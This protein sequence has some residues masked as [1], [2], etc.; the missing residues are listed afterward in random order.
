MGKAE[1]S[2]HKGSHYNVEIMVCR[3]IHDWPGCK[4]NWVEKD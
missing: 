2:R 3:K 4:S 1:V